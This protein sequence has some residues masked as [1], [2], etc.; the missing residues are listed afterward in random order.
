MLVNPGFE[1]GREPWHAIQ[2]RNWG[3][4]EVVEGIARTGSRSARLPVEW[5]RGK[6]GQTAKV[7]GVIQEPVPDRFPDPSL[8]PEK[9]SG[10]YFVE[11]WDKDQPATDLYVQVVVIIWGDPRTGRIVD[12]YNPPKSLTNYQIRYYLAGLENEPFLLKNAKLEFIEKG[13][14][15][16]GE[17]VHF[18]IPLRADFQRLWGVVPTG[19]EKIRVLFEARWDNKPEGSGCSAVVYYD[20][21][22]LG[23]GEP[24]G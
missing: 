9:L 24:E 17:W 20:D 1:S 7:F 4:F 23:W 14:P 21:L 12:P 8:F 3:E 10:W 19:Y 2:N 15:K 13:P 11:S 22:F 16:V 18:D 6:P 5:P